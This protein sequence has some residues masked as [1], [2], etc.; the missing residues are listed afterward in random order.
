[1]TIYNRELCDEYTAK[2]EADP[3]DPANLAAYAARDLTGELIRN[4][5]EYNGL[6]AAKDDRAMNL[7]LAI[8][9]YLRDSQRRCR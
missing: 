1:M 6:R 2:L 4:V 9:Q 5:T 3:M 8:Y 7:E